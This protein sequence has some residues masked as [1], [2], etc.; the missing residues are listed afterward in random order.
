MNNF[1]GGL[2]DFADPAIKLQPLIINLTSEI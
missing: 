1:D 2:V